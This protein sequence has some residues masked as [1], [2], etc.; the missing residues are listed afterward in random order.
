MPTA[1]AGKSHSFGA[2]QHYR[3]L[4]WK[5]SDVGLENVRRDLVQPDYISLVKGVVMG[6]ATSLP[7]LHG[8]PVPSPRRTRSTPATASHSTS[9]RLPRGSTP[10]PGCSS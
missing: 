6:E 5:I 4:Q 9:A 10:A 7:G 3:R 2:F 8:W 1:A